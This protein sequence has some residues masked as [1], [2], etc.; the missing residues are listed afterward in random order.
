MRQKLLILTLIFSGIFSSLNGFQPGEGVYVPSGFAML[1][2][3]EKV[4]ALEAFRS[5][6]CEYKGI[7]LYG[8]VR[9]VKSFPDFKIKYVDAFPDIRVKFV[10]A[11]PDSC[12]KWKKVS[13]FPDFTVQVVDAFPDL[14]V[15]TVSSF[16]GM[17]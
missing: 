12:G 4:E 1:S 3:E 10:D 17:N 6:K 5:G 8:N 14:K 15:K 13:S 16:P 2:E 11:F 9:F 7:S